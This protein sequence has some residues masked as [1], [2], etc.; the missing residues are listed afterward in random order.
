MAAKMDRFSFAYMKEA[1]VATLLML[2]RGTDDDVEEYEASEEKVSES[3]ILG[4]SEERETEDDNGDEFDKYEIWRV[5]VEQVKI[6]REDVDAG[7]QVSKLEPE[8]APGADSNSLEVRRAG[9][10][11]L[12]A[13]DG[14]SPG[15]RG[16]PVRKY[17][18]EGGVSGDVN[19]VHGRNCVILR[20]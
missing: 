7:T 11:I 17:R 13:T 18:P 12:D 19:F 3:D 10:G 9:P 16:L 6:L 5:F 1:F 14:L 8:A 4:G 2:A 15:Q 20:S